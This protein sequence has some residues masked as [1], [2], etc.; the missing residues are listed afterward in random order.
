MKKRNKE[1]DAIMLHE[2]S[3]EMFERLMKSKTCQKRIKITDA[4]N[5]DDCAIFIW[6]KG[7]SPSQVNVIEEGT[8][9]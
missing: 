3:E 9:Q 4:G 8:N 7:L 6:H 2:P 1:F 5:P